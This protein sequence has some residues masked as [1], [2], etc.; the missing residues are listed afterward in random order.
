VNSVPLTFRRSAGSAMPKPLLVLALAA[1]LCTTARPLSAQ[2]VELQPFRPQ[3]EEAPDQSAAR[4]FSSFSRAWSG[5]DAG[6][7][8]DLLPEDGRA[9]VTIESRGV[10]SQMS[11]GQIEALLTGLFSEAERSAFDLSTTHYSDETAAYAVGDWS[12]QSFRAQRQ[13]ETVFVVFR[14]P[15]PGNWVLSELRI[16]PSR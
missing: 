10:S 1:L 8:A 12:Y 7:I 2:E 14:Q 11:R 16:Q 4:M 5:E 15:L 9:S 6:R 3:E 13:R